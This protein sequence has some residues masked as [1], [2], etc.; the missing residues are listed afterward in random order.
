MTRP[1]AR[2]P[3]W[4]WIVLALLLLF[5]VWYRA[6]TFSAMIEA[7][8]GVRLWPVASKATEPVDCD[9]AA[10]AYIGK[11]VHYGDVNYRDLT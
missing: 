10:Y 5:D 2:A 6:H 1:D 8:I 7:Q 9:E 3:R 11:R 4:A